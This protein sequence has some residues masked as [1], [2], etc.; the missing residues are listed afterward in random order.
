MLEPI[1]LEPKLLEP[2]WLR[3][4]FA[5][6][7][8]SA[9]GDYVRHHAL[10]LHC[11]EERQGS[12]WL[13]ALC[14]GTDQVTVPSS[15]IT[16][17][18]HRT[19]HERRCHR[20]NCEQAEPVHGCLHPRCASKITNCTASLE[21]RAEDWIA[22]WVRKGQKFAGFRSHKQRKTCSDLSSCSKA[23]HQ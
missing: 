20:C 19:L 11:L 16:K 15:R 4:L 12:L 10:P 3:A 7:D 5:G 9:I 18:L 2:K 14:A 6:A 1:F 17:P 8:Q 13:L 21:Q 22:T 23:L